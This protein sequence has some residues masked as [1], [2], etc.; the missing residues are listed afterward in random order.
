MVLRE[1]ELEWELE[2][3]L[4]GPSAAPAGSREW[5]LDTS[6]VEREVI[7]RDERRLVI[8]TAVEPYRHI[9]KLEMTFPSGAFIGSGT[10]IAPSKVLTAAHCI[11]DRAS[12]AWATGIR[13]IP[14]KNGA[15]RS[16]RTEPFGFATSGSLNV[17]DA[18]RAAA[19]DRA[20]MPFD[21]GAITLRTPI[22]RRSG[23]WRR[24]GHKPDDFLRRYRVNV[25]GYP[26]D[27]G[28]NT[29]WSSYD[30]IVNVR[31]ELL[32][33]TLDT[34]GGHSGSPVWV[35]WRQYR[36]IVAI[37]TNRDAALPEPPY[38]NVGLRI[39]PRVLADIRR[40][41]APGPQRE[42]EGEAFL[43][44]ALRVVTSGRRDGRPVYRVVRRRLS[45][46]EARRALRG[47]EGVFL[48]GATKDQARQ[49]AQ[50]LA[51]GGTVIE[52]PP[53]LPGGL[54]HFH[55]QRN[56]RSGHIFYGEPPP[57]EFFGVR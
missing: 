21:Y 12:S 11:Y 43:A 26:G 42:A 18:Y 25:C 3:E 31:P 8:N 17:P 27:K 35:R 39:T 56:G 41:L 50:R 13:V 16:A 29:Q 45:D 6:R 36:K 55:V 38:A 30:R 5:E 37:H 57:G 14:G 1:P 24:I 53:H 10:L 7:G 19:S 51:R 20:A 44:R 34:G 54:P 46:T 33:Y 52:D 9:C 28:G 4:A 32:E 2:E 22:G 47:Q 48:S 15:G 49:Y 40:W 23:W